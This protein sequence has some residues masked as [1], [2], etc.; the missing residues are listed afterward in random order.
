MKTFGEAGVRYKNSVYPDQYCHQ[1]VLWSRIH[2][3]YHFEFAPP[4]TYEHVQWE[5]RQSRNFIHTSRLPISKQTNRNEAQEI[6][7]CALE[8]N[9]TPLFSV[10]PELIVTDEQLL[11]AKVVGPHKT[12]TSA[13]VTK[14]KQIMQDQGQ[15]YHV[16]KHYQTYQRIEQ[17]LHFL[18][19][20]KSKF[21][22]E[23]YRHMNDSNGHNPKS[24]ATLLVQNVSGQR[25]YKSTPV[26]TESNGR[27]FWCFRPNWYLHLY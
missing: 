6:F 7:L 11:T 16:R 27:S 13:I 23:K 14:L 22:T 19:I 15:Q 24:L 10:C 17:M 4:F 20:A 1:P 26:T 12:L 18:V 9:E 3:P 8:R 25:C 2:H 5:H 21:W